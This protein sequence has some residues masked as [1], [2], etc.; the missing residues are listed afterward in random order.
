MVMMMMN[1]T[2]DINQSKA[3]PDFKI[4]PHQIHKGAIVHGYSYS[5]HCSMVAAHEPF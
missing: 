2:E 5:L 1:F 4:H 3:S